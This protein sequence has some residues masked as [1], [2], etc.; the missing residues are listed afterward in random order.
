MVPVTLIL[1]SAVGLTISS[2]FTAVA[3]GWI[4]P[5]EKWIPS[6]CRMGEQTCS[7][8]IHLPQGPRLRP[9]QFPAGP[10][11]L[12]CNPGGDL[13]QSDI[14]E[15]VLFP[16]S[17]GQLPHRAA[18]DLSQLLPALPDPD[19][20]CAVLYLSRHQR[21]H[22]PDPVAGRSLTVFAGSYHSSSCGILAADDIPVRKLRA[23]YEDTH[24]P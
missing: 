19:T 9:S 4:D 11:L 1:L 21:G 5:T 2:Y 18:G 12:R 23:P 10:A 17:V 20:L 15:T 14:S 7:R 8:V 24:G 16:V 22:L 3:Y 6:F 13:R